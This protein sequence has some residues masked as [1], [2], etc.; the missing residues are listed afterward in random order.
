MAD[1]SAMSLEQRIDRMES[2]EQIRQLAARYALALD[3]RNFD[4]MVEL[5]I[6]NVQVGRDAFGRDKLRAWFVKTMS[7][8]KSSIHFVGNH[9][10]DL[11]PDDPDKA[12][13]VVYCRDELDRGDIWI[14]GKIQYWDSYERQD[15]DVVLPPPQAHALVRRRRP[16]PP[17]PRQGRDP[18]KRRRQGAASGPAPRCLAELGEVLDAGRPGDS[19]G[20]V[21]ALSPS[22]REGGLRCPPAGE[23]WGDAPPQG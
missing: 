12:R 16:R 23:C 1:G 11:D 18:G 21:P 3:T 5:F 19:V 22:Q 17:R 9:I 4:D 14:V 7:N 20:G 10:I 6:P 8:T 2:T 15:G 13:G